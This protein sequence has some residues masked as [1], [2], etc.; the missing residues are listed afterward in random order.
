MEQWNRGGIWLFARRRTGDDCGCPLLRGMD[1]PDAVLAHSPSDLFNSYWNWSWREPACWICTRSS[2]P[3]PVPQSG[4]EWNSACGPDD[5]RRMDF[6][7]SAWR[8]DGQPVRAGRRIE[9]ER[10]GQPVLITVGEEDQTWPVAQTRRIEATMRAA[11]HNPDVHYFA[12]AGHVFGG[13]DENRR[14]ALVLA[15]LRALKPL[16]TE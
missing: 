2:C 16:D 11:G 5:E 14:R 10:I 4:H 3:G 12:G 8:I 9:V 7:F 1:R 15:F 13:D 6:S